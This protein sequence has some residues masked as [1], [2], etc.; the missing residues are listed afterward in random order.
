M[1]STRLRA[2][3]Q[4]AAVASRGGLP[5]MYDNQANALLL[6]TSEPTNQLVTMMS[7]PRRPSQVA[8]QPVG[9]YRTRRLA[10]KRLHHGLPR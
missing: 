4:I 6:L 3:A 10:K 2:I 7:V 1:R 8:L 9:K 5:S